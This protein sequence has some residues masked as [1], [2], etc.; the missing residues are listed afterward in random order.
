[1]TPTPAKR[2]PTYQPGE[3]VTLKNDP[4]AN[5]WVV[6]STHPSGTVKIQREG[7]PAS[8]FTQMNS[9]PTNLKKAEH[10]K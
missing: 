7:F 8:M 6:V 4:R 3:R 5:P 2:E 1:M 10:T 9:L